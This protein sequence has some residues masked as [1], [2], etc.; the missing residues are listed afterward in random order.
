MEKLVMERIAYYEERITKA[1][2][3]NDDLITAQ[4]I[5]PETALFWIDYEVNVDWSVKSMDEVKAVLK[6]FAKEGIM[7]DNFL[8][9]DTHPTWRLK[10]KNTSIRLAPMWSR[11][12]GSACRLI[13]IGEETIVN[14]VYKL[15][16]DAKPEDAIT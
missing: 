6:A 11:E 1:R 10:G 2:L 3:C 9:S 8:P 15:V 7:L 14:P 4:E 13:K 16:C 5:L 12:E